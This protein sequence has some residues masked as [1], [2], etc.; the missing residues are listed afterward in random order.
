VTSKWSLVVFLE[1]FAGLGQQLKMQGF[2]DVFLLALKNRIPF[3]Y[4][5]SNLQKAG[6]VEVLA[7]EL[8]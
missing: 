7:L 5:M 1:L 8:E 2:P 4:R 3:F 6:R